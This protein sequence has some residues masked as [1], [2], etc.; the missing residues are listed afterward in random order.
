MKTRS[1]LLQ[2]VSVLCIGLLAF[3]ACEKDNTEENK[4]YFGKWESNVYPLLDFATMDTIGYEQMSFDFTNSSFEDQISQGQTPEL[5]VPQLTMGGDIDNPSDN[6]LDVEINKVIISG[7]EISIST[8][9]ELFES[10]FNAYLSSRLNRN[11]EST[12]TIDGD[13]MVL[14]IPLKTPMG[15]VDTP[16][17]LYRK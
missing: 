17:T 2:I 11:F 16:L 3:Y 13:V 14:T 5:V 9:P 15:L 12:Y 1:N 4:P 6:L 10:T 8:Q 7:A